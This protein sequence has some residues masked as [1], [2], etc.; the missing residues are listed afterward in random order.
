[1]YNFLIN[2]HP[3]YGTSRELLC[4]TSLGCD[5]TSIKETV[6]VAPWWEPDRLANIKSIL[7]E[8]GSV[9]VWDC[10]LLDKKFTFIKTGMG[11]SMCTDAILALGTTNCKKIIFLG[12]VGALGSN[13]NIGDIAIPLFSICGDGVCRYLQK[14]ITKDCFG[15]KYYPD[16]EFNNTLIDKTEK[17]CSDENVTYH[18]VNNFSIDTIFAE[19][20]HLDH[21]LNLGCNS[22]EMET[23]AVFKASSLCNIPTV[24]IFSISDNTLQ[25]KSLFNEI[26]EEEHLYR[27]KIRKELIP[28]IIYEI[29]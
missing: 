18:L 20:A 26:N 23:A 19:F 5:S 28:K 16:D 17:L 13:M 24:A 7:I 25:S 9:K 15:E 4:K 27:K 29:I 1:M 3:N 6:I 10:T 21:I 14:D 11:A 22:I 12:S 2:S 8:D